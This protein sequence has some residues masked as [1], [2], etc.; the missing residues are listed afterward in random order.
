MDPRL[1][2][3]KTIIDNYFSATFKPSTRLVEEHRPFFEQL[4]NLEQIDVL[5][6]SISAADQPYYHALLA[7][8]GVSAARWRVTRFP[9][10]DFQTLPAK[11]LQLGVEASYITTSSWSEV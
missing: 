1:V 4:K 2:K 5:G 8:P 7:F 11:L 6:H 9:E 3:A 10:N